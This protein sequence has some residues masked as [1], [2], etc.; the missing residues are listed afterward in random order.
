MRTI[1]G[2]QIHLRVP[3]AIVDDDDIRRLQIDAETASTRRQQEHKQLALGR[4]KLIHRRLSIFARRTAINPAIVMLSNGAIIFQ[5]I[6][7]ARHLTEDEH[8]TARQFQL[9]QQLIEQQQFAAIRNQMLAKRIQAHIFDAVKQVRMIGAFAQLHHQVQQRGLAH[10]VDIA[11]RLNQIHLLQ[12]QLLV[13]ILLQR[14]HADKQDELS[15]GRQVLRHIHLQTTK[16]EWFQQRA[17]LLKDFRLLILAVP[18]IKHR[19]KIIG[20]RKQVGQQEIEQTPQLTQIVLQRRASDQQTMIRAKLCAQSATELRC[21]VLESMR[22]VD[23]DVFIVQSTQH[24]MLNHTNLVRANNDIASVRHHLSRTLVLEVLLD[25]GEPLFFSVRLEGKHAQRR[26]PLG[27]LA[28]PIDDG[29]LR[30]H[31][32]MQ[33]IDRLALVQ[34]RQQS[35]GL[36]RLA[37]PHLIGKDTMQSVMREIDQPRDTLQL[38]ITQCAI[39]NNRWLLV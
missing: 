17:Q 21:I 20:R 13:H 15:L 24:C 28:T 27:K 26:T 33:T 32:Q 2:L 6:Q 36:Q 34:I 39:H 12:Q 4:I 1:H 10:L 35:D 14:G 25:H 9:R 31:H 11:R 22:L 30:H 8:T 23:D 3:I 16:Q 37:Q 5:D 29:R 18:E 38:I 7:N 19:L